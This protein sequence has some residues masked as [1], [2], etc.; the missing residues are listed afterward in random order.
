MPTQKYFDL[1]SNFVI[2]YQ[3]AKSQ[4]IPSVHSSDT[5]NFKVQRPDWLHS[6]LTMPRQKRF[7][8]PLIFVNLYQNTKK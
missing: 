2:T 5:V 8:Q 7:N 1:L 6:F 4:F 3:H